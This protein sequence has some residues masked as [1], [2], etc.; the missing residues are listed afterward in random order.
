MDKFFSLLLLSWVNKSKLADF[1]FDELKS[2]ILYHLHLNILQEPQ[3]NFSSIQILPRSANLSPL[4]SKGKT[5]ETVEK[6]RKQ[7]PTSKGSFKSQNKNVPSYNLNYYYSDESLNKNQASEFNSLSQ[8]Y[9]GSKHLPSYNIISPQ[10]LGKK[11]T[12]AKRLF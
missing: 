3:I 12:N 9:L 4:R 1:D 8:N 11:S 6:F 10:E 7:T 2:Q 5:I